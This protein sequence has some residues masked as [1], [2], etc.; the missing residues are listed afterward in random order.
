MRTPDPGATKTGRARV[1]DLSHQLGAVLARIKAERPGLAMARGW[2]PVPPWVF[3]TGNGTPY[4]QRN[5][6]RDFDRVLVEAGLMRKGE[7]PPFSPHA[8]RHTFATL[9]LITGTDRNAMQYVQQQLG[10][11]SIKVTVDVYGSWLRLRDPAAADRL[12]GLVA[13]G[14]ASGAL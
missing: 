1:V 4:A 12:D 2:R 13:S 9:H 7:P 11:S 5:V 3:I 6:L 10:H 8:L 14:G